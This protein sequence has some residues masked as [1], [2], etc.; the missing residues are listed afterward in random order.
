MIKKNKIFKNLKDFDMF[1]IFYENSKSPIFNKFQNFP[2]YARRQVV[3]RFI[4]LYEIFKLQLKVKG[5]IVDCGV[6][7]GMSLM[8]FA[9]LSTILEPYNYHRKIIGFD[10]F[11]GFPSISK[12]D[13]KNDI[14]KKNGF[15]PNYNAFEDLKKSIDVFDKNRFLNQKKKIEIVKGDATTTI[16]AYIKKNKHLLISL[17]MIDFD[18]YKP[19]KVALDNFL[20][21]MPRG[22]ILV[23]DELNNPDWPGETEAFLESKKIRYNKIN[24][25]EY[26][27]NLSYVMIN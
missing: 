14:S 16:P 5:S 22:S 23:F 3:S 13:K 25:F 27:P 7:E 19:C 11:S 17:L 24:C 12:K 15:K 18:I 26:D 9:Q 20:P 10:T 2:K 8:T 1:R 21:H 6:H 4:A